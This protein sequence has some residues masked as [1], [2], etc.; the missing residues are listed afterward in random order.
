MNKV[1]EVKINNIWYEKWLCIDSDIKVI[2][3]NNIEDD[4]QIFS[5]H[6]LP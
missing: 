3:V 6:V 1:R 5:I 4:G 2:K